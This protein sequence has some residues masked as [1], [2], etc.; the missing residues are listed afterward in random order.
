ME[1]MRQD[2]AQISRTS[3]QSFNNARGKRAQLQSPGQSWESVRTNGR[4]ITGE[5]ELDNI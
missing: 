2:E 5:V 3:V 4:E 1:Q